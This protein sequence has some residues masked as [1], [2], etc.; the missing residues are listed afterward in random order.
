MKIRIVFLF[1]C[2]GFVAIIIRLFSLQV[3]QSHPLSRDYVDTKKVLPERGTI[4]DS[5]RKILA[6]NQITYT[7]CVQP[8]D[9]QDKKQVIFIIDAITHLGEATISAKIDDTKVWAA[10]TSGISKEQKGQIEMAQQPGICF[11]EERSRYYPEASLSAHLLGFTGKDTN[12]TPVGYFGVE[13]FYDKDLTG[14]PGV[15]TSER[16]LLGRPIFFGT[17]EK[18]NSENGRDLIMSVNT[19]VQKIVKTKL[20]K[21]FEHYDVKAGCA[22][23]ADPYTMAILALSCLPDFDPQTYY[24]ASN[25]LYMNPAISTVYEPGSTFKPLIMAASIEEKVITPDSTYQEDGPVRVGDYQIRTWNNKYEGNIT[26]TRILEKS[27][28]VGMVYIGSKL[29]DEKM[30]D[31]IQ[32]YGLGKTTGIDLQGESSG[33]MRPKNNW[34]PIDYATITFGQGIATTPIQMIR[35][36]SAVI[37][38]GNVLQ[39]YVVSE[40]DQAGVKKVREKTVVRRVISEK[41]SAAMRKMLVS[42]VENGEVKWAKPKGYTFGGKTG[43]AQIPIAG[44]YDPTKTI[45]SFMGFVPADHPKFIGMIILKEPQSSQWGS[46]TAAPLFFDI[47]KDLLTYYNILPD[48]AE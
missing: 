47:A 41:T 25:A 15:E 28:N 36:L 40:I 30:Y 9:I 26:M 20:Q 23:F 43:T 33:V 46:E 48:K 5:N 10:V 16:D 24:D 39:P 27:S 19:S 21:A 8:K 35:A 45:A 4:Y 37:N 1:F 32:K 34:Y 11:E 31:Y 29:G 12:G 17:Q 38:G 3:L 42:V 22:I 2:L 7:L 6:S 18:I 13:G 14:L 44:H